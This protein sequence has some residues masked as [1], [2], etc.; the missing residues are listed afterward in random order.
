MQKGFN[1]ESIRTDEAAESE[2]VWFPYLNGSKVK[3]ARYNNEAAEAARVK[4]YASHRALLD[5]AATA[6]AKT[7]EG[8]AL[9]ARASQL[10]Q[11]TDIKVMSEHVIKDWEGFIDDKGKNLKFSPEVAAE[12]LKVK[13]FRKGILERSND[14]SKYLVSAIQADA[15]LAKK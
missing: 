3:L 11:E 7:E 6:D 10:L 1:I 15:E 2:G 9:E 12:Y 5:A 13:D 14:T 8:K 4:I